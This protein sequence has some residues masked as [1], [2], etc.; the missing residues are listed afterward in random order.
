MG[1]DPLRQRIWDRRAHAMM[2]ARYYQRLREGFAERERAYVT[3]MVLCGVATASCAGLAFALP[4]MRWV[5]VVVGTV[6]ALLS[7]LHRSRAYGLEAAEAARYSFY[8]DDRAAEWEN[9]WTRLESDATSVS[10]H[11]VENQVSKD[12]RLP[13]SRFRRDARLEREAYEEVHRAFGAPVPA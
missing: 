10:L 3:W 6:N 9:L 7:A 8:F 1:T 12:E 2:A 4:W 13:V 5:L 11:E